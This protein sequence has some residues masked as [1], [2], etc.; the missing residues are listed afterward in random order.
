MRSNRNSKEIQEQ[1]HATHGDPA[2]DYRSAKYHDPSYSCFYF[3]TLA[4]RNNTV[5]IRNPCRTTSETSS[6]SLLTSWSCFDSI[7]CKVKYSYIRRPAA[8]PC[9]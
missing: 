3:F 2:I 8:R 7:L 9:A 6:D 4:I 5:Y 1:S